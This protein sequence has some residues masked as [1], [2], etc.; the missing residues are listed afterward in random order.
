[1]SR[2]CRICG[3][4]RVLARSGFY[5][6]KPRMALRCRQCE[7]R[8]KAKH[9]DSNGGAYGLR[10]QW[11]AR[12]PE[13]VRAHDAVRYGIKRGKIIRRPCERCGLSDSL[14]HHDDY[15]RPL[16]VTWLCRL[17]HAERHRELEVAACDGISVGRTSGHNANPASAV[18]FHQVM[19]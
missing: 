14:A 8:Y 9:R 13:K 6:G 16:D 19:A 3:G 7:K 5:K 18:S 17:H 2:P 4:D 11:K 10:R 1:M 15:T 12:N